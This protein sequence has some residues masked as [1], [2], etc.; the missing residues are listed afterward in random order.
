MSFP[1]C[2]GIIEPFE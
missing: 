1:A 2:D